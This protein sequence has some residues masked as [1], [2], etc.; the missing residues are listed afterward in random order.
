MK[1]KLIL[2]SLFWITNAFAQNYRGNVADMAGHLTFEVLLKEMAKFHQKGK[3]EYA[4]IPFNRSLKGVIDRVSDFHFPI[5]DPGNKTENEVGFA[6]STVTVGKVIFCLYVNKANRKIT[7][8]NMTSGEFIIETDSAHVNFFDFPVVAS[9]CVKCSLKK[10]NSGR[11]DGYLYSA[12]LADGEIIQE[13]DAY[14]NL[15]TIFFQSYDIKFGLQ[16]GQRGKALDKLLSSFFL[17]VRKTGIY[18]K[19]FREINEFNANWKPTR[20]SE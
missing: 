8:K 14:K 17:E 7:K 11:I 20:K 4:V 10:V 5:L 2:L 12:L 9:T 15:E 6:F 18:D 1:L 13:K 16:K 19:A 3:I